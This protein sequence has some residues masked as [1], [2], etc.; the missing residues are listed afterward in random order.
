MKHKLIALALS[1]SFC[2]AMAQTKI[3]SSAFFANPYL[4]IGAVTTSQSLDLL[5]QTTA[6][7]GFF[8][9]VCFSQTILK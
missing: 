2:S 4:Q 5:W 1:L 6:A 7:F 3:S 8:L 9:Y